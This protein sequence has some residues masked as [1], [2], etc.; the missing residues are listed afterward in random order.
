MFYLTSTI[1]IGD[2][3]NIK[4]AKVS[5]KTDTESF[6]DT[7]TIELP[8]ISYLKT[9]KTSTQDQQ[10][11][12]QKKQYAFKETNNVSVLLGYNNNNTMRFEGFIKRVVMGTPVKIE[13][14]GYSYLLQDVIFSKSYEKVTVKQLLED[15]CKN[16]AIQLSDAIPL[17]PLKNVRF[18]NAS[19]I[20]VLEWLKKECHL[21]VYFNFK[22]L[23]VGTQ[24]GKKQDTI[25]FA[26]GWNTV[27]EDLKKREIDKQQ[28]IVIHEKNEKGESKKTK[29]D[30]AKYSNEKQLKIKAGLP[31]ETLK[32]IANR[33]QTKSNYNGYEGNITAF[34]EPRANKG[35]V[36]K[37]IDKE[38]EERN[39]KFFIESVSGEFG[40]SGGRQTIG[41]GFIVQ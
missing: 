28:K 3:T 31:A 27:E 7:C 29:A 15:V 6:T 19:G 2:Y 8:R 41:L 11:P 13:C 17:I 9:Q 33:L 5:W 21:V 37:I 24:Y 23:F 1:T 39:G 22:E 36:A 34:L 14:E 25:V 20:Q 40:S 18:K 16:T 38:Y 35:M 10:E 32:Q 12:N 26:L 30:V 4:P